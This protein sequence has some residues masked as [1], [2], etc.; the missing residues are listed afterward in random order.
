MKID[1][2]ALKLAH[3]SGQ[4]CAIFVYGTR[5][6]VRAALVTRVLSPSWP[7]DEGEAVISHQPAPF[8][9]WN[10]CGWQ[11]MTLQN[12]STAFVYA[13]RAPPRAPGRAPPA[14]RPP[15]P[16]RPPHRAAAKAGA[17][18]G[19]GWTPQRH[20]PQR[21]RLRGRTA[22]RSRYTASST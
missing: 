10:P 11:Q 12:D 18:A 3:N 9:I 20:R 6:L 17:R 15:R 22:S 2:R 21:A 1:I 14:P 8:P 4:P 13:G 7:S 16:R 5:G 19:S